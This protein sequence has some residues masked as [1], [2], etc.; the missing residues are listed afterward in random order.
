MSHTLP[1]WAGLLLALGATSAFV[2]GLSM[3]DFY[4]RKWRR[5]RAEFAASVLGIKR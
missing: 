5:E 1:F 4:R 3:L 2:V